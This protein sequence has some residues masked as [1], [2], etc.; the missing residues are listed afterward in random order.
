MSAARDSLNAAGSIRTTLYA[1]LSSSNGKHMHAI[2][3]WLQI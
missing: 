1:R 2:S 3:L